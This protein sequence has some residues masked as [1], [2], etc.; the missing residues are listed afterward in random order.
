MGLPRREFLQVLAVAA[1]SGLT[2]AGRAFAAERTEDFY[3]LPAGS[4]DTVTLLHF[5]DCHAQLLPVHFREPDAN[6]GLFEARG[7]PPHL[8]GEALLRRY[9]ISRG[10]RAAHAYTHL[11]FEHA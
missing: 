10:S 7:R 9:G 3:D 4:A 11:D 8:V 2:P 1:A 5:T 6:I